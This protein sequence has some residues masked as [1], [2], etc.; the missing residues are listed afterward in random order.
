[1]AVGRGGHGSPQGHPGQVRSVEAASPLG[2]VLRAAALGVAPGVPG[3]GT[4]G[5][6]ALGQLWVMR[7]RGSQGGWGHPS[8]PGPPPHPRSTP[9]PSTHLLVGAGALLRGGQRA[10]G[11]R[12]GPQQLRHRPPKGQG[13][14]GHHIAGARGGGSVPGPPL[15]WGFPGAER[16]P[17]SS[18]PSERGGPGQMGPLPDGKSQAMA[19]PRHPGPLREGGGGSRSFP[20]CR[21]R[22]RAP[23][24]TAP[25]PGGGGAR[26]DTGVPPWGGAGRWVLWVLGVGC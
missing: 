26:P 13:H 25:S 4:E 12:H 23:R 17:D 22:W 24:S 3:G 16:G 20:F 5:G 7:G 2:S 8:A 21:C 1:M 19:G 9:A 6:D 15:R 10:A 14:R 18:V 11:A